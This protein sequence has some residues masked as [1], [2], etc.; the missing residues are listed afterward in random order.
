[1]SHDEHQVDGHRVS[2][3]DHA[4]HYLTGLYSEE[5]DVFFDRAKE[6]GVCY[7]RKSGAHY[8]MRRNE[9]GLY[10]VKVR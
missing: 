7:F 5:A 6:R 8:E 9:E 10:T 1:M 3:E 2:G 4:I